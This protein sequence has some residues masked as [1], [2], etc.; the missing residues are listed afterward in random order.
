MLNF[1]PLEPSDYQRL[2]PYFTRQSYQLSGYSLPSLIVW[3]QPAPYYA[4]SD[5]TVVIYAESDKDPKD[6]HL[7]LPVSMIG[8][9]SPP[10]LHELARETNIPCYWFISEDYVQRQSMHE[11]EKYFVCEEQPIFEDYIY[12]A[13]DLA[14]LKGNKFSK[15]RN[16]INQFLG[17]HVDKGRVSMENMMPQNADECLQ[18]LEKWCTE[19]LCEAKPDDDFM[20]EKLAVV[21]MIQGIDQ[22][23]IHSLVIRIDGTV[24]AFGI[25]S[26][27]NKDMAVLNFEKAYDSIKGLYQYLD[28][29]C[30]RLICHRYQYINKESDMGL[31][32]LAHAKS[33]YHPVRRVKS[34]K[35][36]IKG[37]L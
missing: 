11:V 2:K 34:Y 8:E 36:T 23:D 37:S 30:A 3:Q 24:S 20:C 21:N 7:I 35:L 10:Q 17:S 18:F 13:S 14:E 32:G 9:Y 15:K 12:L 16:L 31:P 5:D 28:R 22:Y 33:S 4:V 6:K 25:C 27:L 19:Y 29:E 26:H 1:K